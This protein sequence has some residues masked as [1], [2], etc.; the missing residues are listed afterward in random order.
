MTPKTCASGPDPRI[1]EILL[2]RGFVPTELAAAFD[3]FR[4]ANRLA[5]HDLF[6]TRLAS[7]EEGRMLRS[8]GGIEVAV[9]PMNEV[10]APPDILIVTGGAG[11]ARAI[12]QVLPRIQRVRHAGGVVL[13]LSDAAHALLTVGAAVEAAV[14]WEG[15]PVLEESGLADRGRN[16]LFTRSGT[17]VT[18]AGMAATTD[19]VLA[20]VAEYASTALSSDVGRVLLVDRVRQG[21]T[22]QPKG[23][24]ELSGLPEGPLRAALQKM[25]TALE[26]PATTA[27]IARTVGLS[28]RQLE[29]IFAKSLG[30]SPQAYYRRLRLHRARTLIEGSAMPLSEIALSCGFES[31]SHFARVFKDRYGISPHRL[32]ETIL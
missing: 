27:E 32:R 3:C 30:R 28:T 24:S 17:L 6:R 8:L 31:H 15:R 23:L 5:G 29:R 14:H 2:A 4:I 11:M 13:A 22:E 18:S 9:A 1:V 20:L 16:A 10:P 12:R 19:A 21:D 26:F 7:V 25:E